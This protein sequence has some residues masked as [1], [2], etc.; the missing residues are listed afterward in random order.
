MSSFDE[1]AAT[2]DDDPATAERAR[3]VAETIL[4][5]LPLDGTQRLLE[6]GAGTGLVTQAMRS[7]VGPVTLVDNSTGMRDVMREKIAAGAIENARVWDLDLETTSAPAERFDLIVTVL[8][9]H[10]VH[11]VAT[12]LS[13]FAELLDEGGRLCVV[14]LDAEDGSFHGPDADVHKGFGR[15][16]LTRALTDAG[17]TDIEFRDCH[18]VV[19]EQGS[20]PMFLATCTVTPR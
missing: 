12:V 4:D 17:F 9:L 2:W 15:A 16:E 10:H 11:E 13:G 14:D 7:H 1:R 18:T 5:A 19:R 3:S 8:T 6:Y 20:Y